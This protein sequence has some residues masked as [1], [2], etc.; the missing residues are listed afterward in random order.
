MLSGVPLKGV[1]KIQHAAWNGGIAP[2]GCGRRF[3][4]VSVGGRISRRGIEPRTEWRDRDFI[5]LNPSDYSVF[6]FGNNPSGVSTRSRE[7]R[8]QKKG[9]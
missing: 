1:C 6:S 7:S 2:D 5:P 8:Q 3:Q 4:V 9:S